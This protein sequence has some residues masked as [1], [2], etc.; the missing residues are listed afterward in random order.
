ME[1]SLPSAVVCPELCSRCL[2][3][4]FALHHFLPST[5]TS[6]YAAGS[7]GRNSGW[8]VQEGRG[9]LGGSVV[10]VAAVVFL[11]RPDNGIFFFF[12]ASASASASF[13]PQ[14]KLP[15]KQHRPSTAPPSQTPSDETLGDRLRS[16]A[17]TQQQLKMIVRIACLFHSGFLSVCLSTV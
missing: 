3:L 12:S 4:L 15:Q 11:Q 8:L 6:Q 9:L 7:L 1:Y 14:Q 17:W 5:N 10:A 13:T 2:E 16:T